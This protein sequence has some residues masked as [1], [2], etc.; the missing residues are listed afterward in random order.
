MDFKQ[1]LAAWIERSGLTYTALVEGTGKSK[2][3]I[4]RVL[5]GELPVP[6]KATCDAIGAKLEQAGVLVSA[7]EVWEAAARERIATLDP[8]LL[9]FIEG[10]SP[11]VF[12]RREQRLLGALAQ[13][14][15]DLSNSD[16]L[17]FLRILIEGARAPDP[18]TGAV[19][20]GVLND[21]LRLLAQPDPQM[22][23]RRLRAVRTLLSG[24]EVDEHAHAH[25]VAH[26][27]VLAHLGPR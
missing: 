7:D 13:L 27:I 2:G 5:K 25:R 16:P 19:A 6:D 24:I 26:S 11:L 17:G 10:L 22:S 20:T 14:A 12:S 8:D 3:Y 1:V 21:V 4:G 9:P 15:E 23:H 18:D